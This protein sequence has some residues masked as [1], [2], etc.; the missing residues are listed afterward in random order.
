MINKTLKTIGIL[1]FLILIVFSIH[2]GL[3][4]VLDLNQQTLTKYSLEKLYL[5]FSAFSL[6]LVLILIRVRQKNLDI[7]GNTFLLLT[8]VK[9]VIAYIVARPILAV[10]NKENNLE[11]WN[12]FI[13]FMLFLCIETIVTIRLLNQ[14]D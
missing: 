10:T 8:T 9:L 6:L 12:F 2:K 3:F 1:I 4:S 14:K 13:L 11:K 7:V 5:C